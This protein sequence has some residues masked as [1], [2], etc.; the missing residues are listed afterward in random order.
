MQ[1]FMF[2]FV[3]SIAT[4]VVMMTTDGL[5]PR[6]RNARTNHSQSSSLSHLHTQLIFTQ[7]IAELLMM[8]INR[9][10]RRMASAATQ[11]T[12]F[13]CVMQNV[14]ASAPPLSHCG[15]SKHGRLVGLPLIDIINLN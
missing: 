14:F 4:N 12:N 5:P 1:T 2:I 3:P 7:L 13:G 11:P 10:R 9:R 8:M 6:Q 15:K